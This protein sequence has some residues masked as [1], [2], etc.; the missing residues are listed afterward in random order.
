[1]GVANAI[2]GHLDR[3]RDVIATLKSLGATGR[4]VF[5]IYLSQTLL[6]ASIGALPGLVIG[7]ALPFLINWVFG[8]IIPLP[9]APA[10]HPGN[11]ALAFIYGVMTALALGLCPRGAQTLCRS[12]RFSAMGLSPSGNGRACPTCGRGCWWRPRS[13][14]SPSCSP[15]TAVSP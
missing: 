14:R 1:V 12:R 15:P 10:L 6:L 3:K 7:A 11:L 4:S 9:L 5:W 2:K 13:R 8:A